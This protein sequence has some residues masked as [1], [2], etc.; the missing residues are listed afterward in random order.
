MIIDPR[1]SGCII[2]FMSK[3]KVQTINGTL[4][5]CAD[6]IIKYITKYELDE[7]T[8][9]EKLIQWC[10]IKLDTTCSIGKLY[11]EYFKDKG[12]KF[13]TIKVALDIL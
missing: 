1:R 12:I 3:R 8:K 2:W 5:E 13:D 4:E 11:A 7:E 10:Y 6:R 9:E